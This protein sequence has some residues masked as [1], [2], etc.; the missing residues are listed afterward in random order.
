MR[1]RPFFLGG[2][3]RKGT[4]IF[5]PFSRFAQMFNAIVAMFGGVQEQGNERQSG[6]RQE[7]R[8]MTTKYSLFFEVP[9][10]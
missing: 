1:G 6:A 5:V 7:E 8:K 3:Y 2:C 9:L 10:P 4:E